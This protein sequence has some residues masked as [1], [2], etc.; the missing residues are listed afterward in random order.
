MAR[1]VPVF[2]K[3]ADLEHDWG[4]YLCTRKFYQIDEWD[5]ARY[6]ALAGK[7]DAHVN[8]ICDLFLE[9][10]RAANYICDYVREFL[11]PGFRLEQGALIVVR[12]SVGF[13]L[14]T[15]FLRPEYRGNERVDKPYP[16]LDDFLK[17]RYT[18]NCFISPN[19][20]EPPTGGGP[21]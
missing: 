14:T 19:D 5:E 8:L 21:A 17:V 16:G 13:D 11:F 2:D 12:F 3:H 15:N 1:K 20:P 6:S 10:T 18:R 9:L 7:Y 4:G